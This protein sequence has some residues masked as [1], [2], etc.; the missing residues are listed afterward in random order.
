MDSKTSIFSENICGYGVV[1]EDVF[2]RYKM[3]VLETKIE[4]G[5]R[6]TKT[7]LINLQN[8]SK[9]LNRPTS[10]ILKYFGYELGTS[11]QIIKRDNKY[12]LNGVHDKLILKGLLHKFISQY[13]ICP[14]CDN[15]ETHIVVI[16][17]SIN[18]FCKTC[19]NTSKLNNNNNK[20]E[21]FILK[22]RP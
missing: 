9:A 12:I 2:Y 19:G 6:G 17:T 8:I 20:M 5:G 16:K 14:N 21:T 10:T 3:P 11:T 4:G 1:N 15:P 22:Q 13:V 7:L 18:L